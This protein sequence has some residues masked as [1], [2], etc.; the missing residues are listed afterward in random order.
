M[1]PRHLPLPRGGL[2]GRLSDLLDRD[3]RGG[4]ARLPRSC[5]CVAFPAR[6]W[7]GCHRAFALRGDPRLVRDRPRRRVGMGVREPRDRGGWR[8]GLCGALVPH[9]GSGGPASASRAALRGCPMRPVRTRLATAADAAA[10][11][12]IYNE[13]IA[14]RIAT[15]ETEPRTTEQ[16]TQQLADKGD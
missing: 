16:L 9:A 3:H 12:A 4:G 14:D 6:L 10:I 8:G 1:A 15:F 11:A 13:G 7:R 2:H 5:A